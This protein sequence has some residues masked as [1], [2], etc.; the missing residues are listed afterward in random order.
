[1]EETLVLSCFSSPHSI[2]LN[3][4]TPMIPVGRSVKIEPRMRSPE[5]RFGKAGAPQGQTVGLEV[6]RSIH[7][8]QKL[9][10]EVGGWGQD[11]IRSA[12]RTESLGVSV[13]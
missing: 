1:M 13:Q 9:G 7:E 12:K 2:A 5:Y 6:D 8:K 11:A 3:S 10:E 4:D